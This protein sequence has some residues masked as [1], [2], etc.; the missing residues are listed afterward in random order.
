MWERAMY[1]LEQA[2]RYEGLQTRLT[3]RDDRQNTMQLVMPLAT[4]D[5]FGPSVRRYL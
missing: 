5:G 3:S 2:I 1:D 4:D